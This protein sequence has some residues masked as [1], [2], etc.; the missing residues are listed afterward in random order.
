MHYSP[1]KLERVVG[2]RVLQWLPHPS[3]EFSGKF[4]QRSL[5]VLSD[6][7]PG[8]PPMKISEIFRHCGA[9][10]R[11]D[12]LM[13]QLQTR[14]SHFSLE[15]TSPVCK[16]Q[17]MYSQGV[18]W[19]DVPALQGYSQGVLWEDVPALQGYYQGVLWEDVPALPR[20]LLEYTWTHF[21]KGRTQNLFSNQN[22]TPDYKESLA[23]WIYCRIRPIHQGTLFPAPI[24]STSL[25]PVSCAPIVS[26]SW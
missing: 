20:Y 3:K 17:K 16:F 5:D 10:Y 19:E 2:G 25:L 9:N 15:D 1:Q 26:N 4:A 13:W 21:Q 23:T 14:L 8:P 6:W 18:L 11:A 24:R 22:I 12:K 7:A